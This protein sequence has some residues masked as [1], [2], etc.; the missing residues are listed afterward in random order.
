M[1]RESDLPGR[2]LDDQRVRRPSQ[3]DIW[4]AAGKAFI[5]REEVPA[6]FF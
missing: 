2:N 4:G 1:S 6:P 5:A 3:T